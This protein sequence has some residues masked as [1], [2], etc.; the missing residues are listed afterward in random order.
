MTCGKNP[1]L[2]CLLDQMKHDQE[3]SDK[4]PDHTALLNAI[5][6]ALETG[7]IIWQSTFNFHLMSS[8]QWIQM[9]KADPEFYFH[10]AENST[11]MREYEYLL[12]D[13]ASQC[14]K[15]KIQQIPF[16]EQED[17]HTFKLTKTFLTNKP[18]LSILSCQNLM[19]ENFFISIQTI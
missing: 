10:R 7:I 17:G 8:E 4:F 9:M 19:H 15:R 12:L 18:T 5:I 13:L 6:A 1:I 14:L 11:E 16:L 2:I 3:L